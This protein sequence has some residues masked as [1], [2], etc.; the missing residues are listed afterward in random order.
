M[1]LM[2]LLF[3]D[4]SQMMLGPLQE[5]SGRWDAWAGVIARVSLRGSLDFLEW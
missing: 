4:T 3:D 1:L 2:Q 5:G